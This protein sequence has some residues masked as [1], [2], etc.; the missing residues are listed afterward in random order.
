MDEAVEECLR[1]A[2]KWPGAALDGPFHAHEILSMNGIEWPGMREAVSVSPVLA[3]IDALHRAARLAHTGEFS[4][5]R[6]LQAFFETREESGPISPLAQA[7]W[8]AVL[9]DLLCRHGASA[10]GHICF[11]EAYEKA[12]PL[13]PKVANAVARRWREHARDGAPAP[14]DR[15]TPRADP[16]DLLAVAD[17]CLGYF[18]G[19]GPTGP[20]YANGVP[21]LRGET[22]T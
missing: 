11:A 20:P 14:A 21:H 16:A 12:V 10:A 9:A 4:P 6:H 2:G 7:R 18:R 22:T 1:L 3:R 5:R 8:L 15:E 13:D 19:A 17:L